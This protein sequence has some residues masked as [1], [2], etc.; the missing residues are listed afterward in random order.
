[1]TANRIQGRS[2]GAPASFGPT[3]QF[4]A[5]AKLA[6]VGPSSPKS[7]QNKLGRLIALDGATVKGV[8]GA[9]TCVI[10]SINANAP[11]RW[12]GLGCC[13]LE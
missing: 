12:H 5:A 4:A 8:G 7:S 9:V 10:R 1:M 13:K 3:P 2:P 11:K 6:E